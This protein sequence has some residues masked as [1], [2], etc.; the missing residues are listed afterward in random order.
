MSREIKFR[1]WNGKA[2]VSDDDWFILLSGR[3]H[4]DNNYSCESQEASVS[5][6]DFIQEET[7]HVE[8]MQY[9]GFKDK[10]GVEIYE[11]DILQDDEG[12]MSEVIWHEFGR[13]LSDYRSDSVELCEVA[14]YN[15]VVGNIYQNPELLDQ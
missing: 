10:N 15:A 3:V 6:E 2:M 11:G 14:C 12:Y 5:F 7:G 8:L 1:A 4:R 13:W 9:T